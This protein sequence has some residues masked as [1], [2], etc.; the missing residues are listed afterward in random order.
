MYRLFKFSQWCVQSVESVRWA[1]W[2][3]DCGTRTL[4]ANWRLFSLALTNLL[5]FY[6]SSAI[7]TVMLLLKRANITMSYI[8]TC[9]PAILVSLI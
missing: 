5:T 4:V 3:F 1:E 6:T 7:V 9:F 2:I 8:H